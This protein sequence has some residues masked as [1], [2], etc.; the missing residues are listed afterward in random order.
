[1]KGYGQDFGAFFYMYV[2]V[3]VG[4]IFKFKLF[5]LFKECVRKVKMKIHYAVHAHMYYSNT[6]PSLQ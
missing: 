4:S 1:M 3:H 6:H 2:R 5:K